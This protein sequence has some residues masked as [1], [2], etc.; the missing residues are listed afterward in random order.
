MRR[1]FTK[2]P[3]NYVKASYQ[4]DLNSKRNNVLCIKKPNGRIEKY[5]FNRIDGNGD[6]FEPETG[7]GNWWTSY[8]VTPDNRL[9]SWEFSGRYTPVDAIYGE[10][11]WVEKH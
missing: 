10:D 4:D 7:S 3:N 6:V 8:I 2:Y 9:L 1:T 5:R 11:F